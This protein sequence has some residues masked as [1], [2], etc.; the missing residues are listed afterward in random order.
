MFVP[1]T[2]RANDSAI[3][4]T[5]FDMLS[6]EAA[7]M[8][9]PLSGIGSRLVEDVGAQFGTEGSWSGHPWMQLSEPYAA[10]KEA[11]VSGL[12]ILV[13][14]KPEHKGTRAKPTRPQHYTTS[15]RMRDELLDMG[16][17]R[18]SPKRMLYA[19]ISDI[20]GFHQEGTPKMPARPP[21]DLTLMELHEWDRIF[22]RWMNGLIAQASLSG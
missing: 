18:V 6:R 16:S 21:V 17:V 22:V 8:T 19:P 5:G 9:V 1:V 15:G 11:R 12:P 14:I 13:G 10:W 4:Q 20:A 3:Y 2:I 7:D